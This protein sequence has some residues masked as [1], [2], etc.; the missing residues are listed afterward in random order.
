L[1]ERLRHA[2]VLTLGAASHG[3]FRESSG[4]SQGF[5]AFDLSAVPPAGQGDTDTSVT[6][7][8]LT[9]AAIKLLDTRAASGA[10]FFLWVHYFDPHLQYVAHDGAPDFSDPAKPAGWRMHAAYDGEVWFTDRRSGGCS[11]TSTRSPGAKIRS[12]SSRVTTERR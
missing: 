3:Y 4:L 7:P 5:D 9:D 2:G 1:A 10:R 8:Q 11:I 12:W 6:G